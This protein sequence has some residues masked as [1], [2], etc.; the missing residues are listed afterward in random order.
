M[1]PSKSTAAAGVLLVLLV[2]AAG[3]GAEAAATT[4]VASLL[5]LSPCL[6]FFK[7]KAATA[8]PEG[9]CAGL[10]SIVKGEAVCLCHIVNHT[11][12]RAIG[13]DIP[14][15]RAFALLRDVCR[16]SPPADI[17]STCANEKGGVPPLY[18][19]PAPSA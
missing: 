4:C 1:A 14:V 5:E 10:S 7:D 13:V 17:I 9:C 19:C 6:P 2:A 3:G 12:E 16:L 15:D 11:L 8:A 18:S